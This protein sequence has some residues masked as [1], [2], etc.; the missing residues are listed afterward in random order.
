VPVPRA[1]KQ[2]VPLEFVEAEALRAH[3]GGDL[4]RR[5][6]E[7]QQH[8][9]LAILPRPGD[10]ELPP[11]KCFPGPALPAT[12]VTRLRGRPLPVMLSRPLIPVCALSSPGPAA[13]PIKSGRS[14]LP[15]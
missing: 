10:E 13:V 5:L 4:G 11:Q 15:T 12:S 14:V 6:P 2:P 8:P 1:G 3:V 9:G 7:G